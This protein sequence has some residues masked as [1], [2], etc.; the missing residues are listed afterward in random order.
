MK[1]VLVGNPDPD[2]LQDIVYHGLVT[3]LGPQNVVDWPRIPRYHEKPPEDARFPQLWFGFPDPHRPA[4]LQEAVRD[5]D[6][7][8]LGSVR[9]SAFAAVREAIALPQR[10][11][12]AYLDG[13]DDCYV[14]DIVAH[15]DAYFKRETLTRRPRMITPLPLQRAYFAMGGSTHLTGALRR[16]IAIARS[17]DARVRPLPFGIIDGERPTRRE[18]FD[19]AFMGLLSSKSRA[20]VAPQLRALEKSG[21]RV[22]VPDHILPWREY[23]QALADSRACVSLRGGG[24]DTYRYWEIPW[25]GSLLVSE[26]LEIE[27]PHD[28]RDG[29]EAV[30]VPPED[31]ASALPRILGG[32]T[33]ALAAAGQ[34]KLMRHHVST[35][36][37]RV[38]LEALGQTPA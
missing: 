8:V 19:V 13:E 2:Y 9:D 26:P 37:A 23:L 35:E 22:F 11:P 30:F 28:F 36:R 38:V 21:L 31:L 10:P 5:A 25:V 12:T 1:V 32:D 20:R 14:R 3:L 16:P 18:R 6:A 27:I 24:W 15:V 4:S 17:G 29:E 34:R 7:L 33:A